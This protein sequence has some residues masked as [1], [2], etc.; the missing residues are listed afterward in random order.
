MRTSACEVP[1]ARVATAECGNVNNVS[2]PVLLQIQ[3]KLVAPAGIPGHPTK[4]PWTALGTADTAYGNIMLQCPMIARSML[5]QPTVN[6]VA[7]AATPAPPS[8]P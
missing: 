1:S 7:A 2:A 4:K 5:R 6:S 3:Y 8:C